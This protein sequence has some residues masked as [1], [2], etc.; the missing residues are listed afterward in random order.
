MD[1]FSHS[2]RP[3]AA[4]PHELQ[5]G[6][7]L[8]QL[9]YGGGVARLSAIS[10]C[11]RLRVG[12]GSGQ[13]H[14]VL[15]RVYCFILQCWLARPTRWRPPHRKPEAACL[16]WHIDSCLRKCLLMT[17]CRGNEV[18][19]YIRAQH[20]P[21]QP[22]ASHDECQGR[23]LALRAH[24]SRSEHH[25]MCFSKAQ[26]LVQVFWPLVGKVVFLVVAVPELPG[27]SLT[28]SLPRQFSDTEEEKK[29][30]T[31][32]HRH[33]SI[34]QQRKVI[35]R[36]K[37]Q[38]MTQLTAR[39]DMSQA[40]GRD[41]L[42]AGVNPAPANRRPNRPSTVQGRAHRRAFLPARLR[43]PVSRLVSCSRSKP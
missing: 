16:D 11:G 30:K 22:T 20:G 27:A 7:S 3:W 21:V 31:Q 34:F 37:G 5:S 15:D 26:V 4:P 13:E 43:T 17:F 25:L 10:G 35:K 18:V 40:Y 33:K 29:E 2:S 36:Q 39:M 38:A 24:C 12:A 32:T 23:T 8:L 9:H 41:G 19:I 14:C 28:S 6:V 1:P 42:V